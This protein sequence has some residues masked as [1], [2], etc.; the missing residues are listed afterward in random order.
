M[1][2]WRGPLLKTGGLSQNR[3]NASENE[4][5]ENGTKMNE[6]V[7]STILKLENKC[8]KNSETVDI[9][10]VRCKVKENLQ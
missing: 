6:T 9:Q 8:Q 10:T 7:R 5:S 4:A 1:T 2:I 3:A